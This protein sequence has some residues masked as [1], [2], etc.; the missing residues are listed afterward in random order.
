MANITTT[1]EKAIKR[2]Q[3]KVAE[4]QILFQKLSDDIDNEEYNATL[5]DYDI[6]RTSCFNTLRQV[7]S[8]EILANKFLGDETP[9]PSEETLSQKISAL[10]ADIKTDIKRLK[11]TIDDLNDNIYSQ[12]GDKEIKVAKIG[13]WTT[14][15]VAL[16]TALGG[17]A[18][19][20]IA[21]PHK[22]D[23]LAI[24]G[25]E[26]L[27]L[28][29]KWKYICTSFDGSYQH[30]GRFSVQKER[31][32]S[33]ILNGERMWRDTKD[34]ISNKWTDKNYAES[35]YLQ[36][37]TNWIFVKNDLKIN[38]E[39]EIP[40]KDRTVTGYCTGIIDAKNGKVQSVKGNFYVLNDTPILTGQII[41][42]KVS[43]D[44]FSSKS[45]LAKNHE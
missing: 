6:W 14:I 40:M 9:L 22:P 37:H 1:K 39:Y 35:D 11:H 34:T 25:L 15:I 27:S 8:D 20:Y 12:G 45:T 29:G 31:D 26:N 21:L 3:V 7:F 36:W 17:I 33:L 19:G 10:K 32:G 30:G 13:L 2:I 44:D 16:I 41:F 28:E 23:P 43:D 4:G 38:F 18:T 42:K 24:Q 5:N